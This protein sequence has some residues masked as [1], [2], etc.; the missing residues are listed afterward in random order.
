MS[1]DQSKSTAEFLGDKPRL[2]VI[3]LTWPI[4]LDG[5]EYREI[6]LARMTAGEVIAFQ[7]SLKDLAADDP[8]HWPIFRDAAGEMIPAAVLGMLDDDDKFALDKA[9]VDFLP[10][11]FLAVADSDTAPPAGDPTA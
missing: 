5:R 6:H 8:V 2:R 7:K 11:R 3:D 9:A 4:R 10:L 1:N